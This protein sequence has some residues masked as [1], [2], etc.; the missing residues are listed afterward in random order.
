MVAPES[1]T[2]P[3]STCRYINN[4]FLI[5]I[6][7]WPVS[8]FLGDIHTV[9]FIQPPGGLLGPPTQRWG[10]RGPRPASLSH[11]P[12]A[13]A[14]GVPD[15]VH[16]EGLDDHPGRPHGQRQDQPGAAA[17]SADGTPAAGHGHE[18]LHGHH[19]ATGRLRAG[20]RL[21]SACKMK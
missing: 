14:P 20:T 13:A 15:E 1:F 8:F 10:P 19:R 9:V 11:A 21:L 2:S 7:E 17:G 4:S 12:G 3:L 16:G 5:S 6:R 18:Q